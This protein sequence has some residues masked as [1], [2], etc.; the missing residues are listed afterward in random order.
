MEIKKQCLAPPRRDLRRYATQIYLLIMLFLFPLFTG[1]GGYTNITFSKYIF[2]IS[3]TALWAAFILTVSILKRLPLK[4]PLSAAVTGGGFIIA[5]LLSFLLSPYKSQSLLGAGRYD[6]L[7]TLLLY[8]LILLGVS[9]FGEI[10][11]C[12][13]YAFAASV[14]ACC[15]VAVLQLFNLDILNLFPGSVTYYDAHT[16]YTGEFLGTM[17]NANVLSTL[18][19]LAIPLFFAVPVISG[20]K[21][22]NWLFAALFISAFTLVASGV[23]SGVLACAACALLCAPLLLNCVTRLRRA[24]AA[25][26]LTLIAVAMAI[27]LDC[28]FLD[29]EFYVSFSFGKAAALLALLACI[30]LMAALFLRLNKFNPSAKNMQVFFLAFAVACVIICLAV[31]YFYPWKSGTLYELSQVLHGSFSDKFGSSRI[32]IWR[33]TLKLVPSRLLFGGGPDTLAL[34]LDIQFSRFVPETGKTLSTYVDN[35][36]NEYLGYLVNLGLF[37]LLAYLSVI[38]AAFRSFAKNRVD[39]R[40]LPFGIS[41][42]CY[43]IQSFFS[44]GTCLVVPLFWIF[45]GLIQSANNLHITEDL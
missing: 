42:V 21:R 24:L 39:K 33:K 17:G 14:S 44:I 13:I 28:G 16:L 15:A 2:F 22:D 1:F 6:G 19:C 29:G 8:G 45:L 37:G 12:H 32:E 25:F 18:L 38:F 9:A 26:A 5:A 10:R 4:V 23:S 30:C 3:A 43:S 11:K 7:I 35:A 40:L 34:R 27:S 36:H 31:I 20:E 41:L